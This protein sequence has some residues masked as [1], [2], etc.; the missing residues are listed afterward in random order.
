MVCGEIRQRTADHEIFLRGVPQQQNLKGAQ[1]H[2]RERNLLIPAESAKP[3]CKA[4]S[5]RPRSPRVVYGRRGW[6]GVVRREIQDR[7][8]GE[9]T[10]P[11]RSAALERSLDSSRMRDSLTRNPGCRRF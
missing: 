2:N 8:T 7:G 5:H 6:P 9:L 10:M 3:F 11:I 4:V 1:E